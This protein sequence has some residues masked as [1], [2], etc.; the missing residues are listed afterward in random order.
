MPL[1]LP[2]NLKSLAAGL[3]A[4]AGRASASPEADSLP[5]LDGTDF[6]PF[7]ELGR[8][9]MGVVHAALAVRT[10]AAFAQNACTPASRRMG[11]RYAQSNASHAPSRSPGIVASRVPAAV[12]TPAMRPLFASRVA[13]M[14]GFW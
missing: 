2:D 1:E 5:T 7:A 11:E 14:L 10:S 8:G 9:G 3:D 13:R 6:E 12:G 4:P